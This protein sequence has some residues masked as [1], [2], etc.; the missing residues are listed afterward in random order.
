MRQHVAYNVHR[1]D[2]K[3]AI[4][5]ANV[6]MHPKDQQP[7]RQQLHLL[8]HTLVARQRRHRLVKPVA[9]RMRRRRHHSQPFLRRQI[10]DKTALLC[11]F[12]ARLFQRMTNRRTQLD[13]GLMQFWLD[14]ALDHDHTFAVEK[15]RDE[16]AQFAR[17]R[18]DDLIF[19]FDADGQRW[20]CAH[21][22]F[23][24]SAIR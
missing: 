17:L 20:S 8:Q 23:S 6:D 7:L 2:G 3:G 19:L 24:V 15:L 10:D 1:V 13:H 4:L 5:D 14:L 11:Q 16:R 9:E 22:R 21:A 18:I 12:V